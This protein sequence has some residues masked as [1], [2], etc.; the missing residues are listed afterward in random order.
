MQWQQY[1][2]ADIPG[3]GMPFRRMVQLGMQKSGLGKL[4]LSPTNNV[5]PPSLSC[6]TA[7]AMSA[8]L[9]S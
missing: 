1:R 9:H 5:F 4:R 8:E 7:L 2:G 6:L 3:L